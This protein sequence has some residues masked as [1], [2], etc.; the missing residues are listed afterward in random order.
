MSEH[1]LIRAVREAKPFRGHKALAIILM[2]A[3]KE[4]RQ[5]SAN[6]DADQIPF[7]AIN[8]S[9]VRDSMSEKVKVVKFLHENKEKILENL[10]QE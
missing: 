10:V 7:K 3:Q 5:L 4:K 8:S 9:Y 6:K 1:V 2:H